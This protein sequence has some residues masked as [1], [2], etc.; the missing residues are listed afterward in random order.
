MTASRPARGAL[1]WSVLL[2]TGLLASACQPTSARPY[3]PP[4]TGAA[5]AEVRLEPKNAT[6]ALADVLSSDSLP[7]ARVEVRDGYLETDWF[8]ASSKRVAHGRRLGL[9][10]V[11]IRAWVD[12]TRAGYSRLTVETVYRPLADASLSP[13]ELDRQVPPDHPVGKRVTEIVTELSKLYAPDAPPA[14]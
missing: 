12:P 11:Q 7:V 6:A 4:V 2:G 5:Q 3:F 13:R 14:N 9:D 10:V 8:Q 1:T